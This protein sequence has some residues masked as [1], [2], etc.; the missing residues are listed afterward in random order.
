MKFYWKAIYDDGEEFPQYNE[1]GS[2][3]LY[4]DIKRKRLSQFVLLQVNTDVVIYVLHFTKPWQR[5]ICRRR[6]VRPLI[7]MTAKEQESLETVWLV[8][9]HWKHKGQRQQKLAFIFQDGHI[10]ERDCFEEESKFY[11]PCTFVLEDE[12]DGVDS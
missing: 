1:D 3:N 7:P 4:K 8:G 2:E 9:Q 11:Y 12:L 6:I 5:L 10:E